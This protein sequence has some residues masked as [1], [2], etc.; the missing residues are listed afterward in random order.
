MTRVV[1]E[2][3]RERFERLP[4]RQRKASVEELRAIARRAGGSSK[5]A[6]RDHAEYL[7]DERGLPK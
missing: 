2:A 1:T 3:L 4:S 5:G 6:Y 7:Y